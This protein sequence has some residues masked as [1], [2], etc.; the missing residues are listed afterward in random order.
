MRSFVTCTVL[1]SVASLAS[2]SIQARWEY[3]EAVPA[4][5]RRQDPGTPAY[6]CHENCGLLITLGRTDGFCDNAEWN[7]RYDACMACANNFGIWIYYRNGVTT[8]AEKCAPLRLPLL[9]P[10]PPLPP[11]PSLLPPPPS[12]EESSSAPAA[13]SAAAPATTLT[14]AASSAASSSAATPSASGTGAAGT[15]TATATRVTS[16]GTS[17][18]IPSGTATPSSPVFAGASK[19]TGVLGAVG[20]VG[21]VLAAL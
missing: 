14:T 11:P 3:P 8:A 16:I 15:S 17:V 20:V 10:S 2:A 13:T 19:N 18:V 4:I 1:A 6:A 9:P 5:M 21:L 12:A 7:T